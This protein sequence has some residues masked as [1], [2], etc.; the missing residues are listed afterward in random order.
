MMN[1]HILTLLLFVLSLQHLEAKKIYNK[2]ELDS[3]KKVAVQHRRAEADSIKKNVVFV[4][5]T[6]DYADS[7]LNQMET[8]HTALNNITNE[9]K[10]SFKTRQIERELH[11]MQT[12][13]DIITESLSR[14]SSVVNINNLQLY[15]GLLKDMAEKLHTWKGVLDDDH[16]DLEDKIDQMN[17]FVR[18]SFTEKIAADTAFANLH[19]DQMIILNDRWKQAKAATTG[20]L[21]RI[22]GLQASVSGSNF[23]VTELANKVGL[24]L[25]GAGKKTFGQEYDYV[26]HASNPSLDD[27]TTL[28][29]QSVQ[30]RLTVLKYYLSLNTEDWLSIV[31][32]GLVFFIWV[33]FNF[34]RI[35]LR[36]KED[37]TMDE[38]LQYISPA[39]FLAA[40]IFILALAPYYSFDQPAV[41]I[42]LIQLVMLIPITVLAFR[43]WPR[44]SIYYWLALAILFVLTSVMNAIITPGWP[45][46]VFLMIINVAASVYGIFLIR[47]DKNLISGRF[48]KWI[49][50]IFILLNVLA[51][52]ANITGRL[53]LAKILTASAVIGLAQIIGLF[54]L[55]N[56]LVEA[57]YL[58]MQSSRI[59]GGMT[60]KFNYAGIRK[61]LYALL[62][63]VVLILWLI[64][65]LTNLEIYNAVLAILDTIFNTPRAIG[66]TTFTF[67][68]ILTFGLILY[69][70]SVLQKYVGYFFGETEEEFVGDLDKKESSL[71]I[72]RLVIIM[73]GFFMAVVAS[74]LPVDKVTVVLGALG[75][76]IGLGLQN[77]V[78][79]LVSGV[80]LIFEKPMQIGDYIEVGDK[81]GRVQN[82]GIRSSKLI[83]SD[84]SEVI[85]P[86][87]DILS[88]H[89]VN[90][91]RSNN[92]RRA[93]LTFSVEPSAQ[94]QLAKDTI[95]AELKSSTFVIQD[96][97]VEILVNNLSEKTADL[98]I[99]VWINSIYKEQEFKSEIISSLYSA[100]AAKGVKIV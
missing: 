25:A 91:T 57:F 44:K 28:T 23:D 61:E 92:N 16:D 41:Y 43:A 78:Y 70:V 72:F 79:N 69:V 15:R 84:G 93:E 94:L 55:V 60:V 68:N 74:G 97:P 26:W 8:F 51:L 89:M 24:L 73:V 18:D 95:V 9:T 39:P 66:S 4:H 46:R 59:A 96:R 13:I 82:I 49:T 31:L 50:V 52:A 90:W 33:A 53:T 76:G 99:Y 65:F 6:A 75:V 34:R 77:I 45:L 100:L 30:E 54:A 62:T 56:I 21:N 1:R 29:K 48:T 40:V 35:K 14:D 83:T 10:Y 80:I 63:G 32:A 2:F 71:V 98:T 19:L 38:K 87:G 42:E 5:F 11:N 37:Y 17:A 27:V 85:V 86:N 58:Q 22:T 36:A 47:N 12:N 67:G 88:S 20:N 3:L 7:L 81:K 64:T